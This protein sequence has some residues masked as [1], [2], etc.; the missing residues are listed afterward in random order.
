MGTTSLGAS[1]L[2]NTEFSLRLG[3]LACSADRKALPW[4]GHDGVYT[5][6]GYIHVGCGC[7]WGPDG[8][9]ETCTDQISPFRHA[10]ED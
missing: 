6:L 7:S 1:G 2:R 5:G 10:K 3:S 9:Q 8:T 4:S